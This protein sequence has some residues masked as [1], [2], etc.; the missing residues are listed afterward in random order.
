MSVRFI[1]TADWQLG[2]PF[3]NVPDDSKRAALQAE[4]FSVIE[5]IASAAKTQDAGFVLIAGDLFDSPSPTKSVVSQACAAIG[6]IECPVLLIPGNHDHGGPGSVWTQPFF[7]AELSALAPNL[8]VLLEPAPV[9]LRNAVIFPCPLQRR[10]EATDTTAWLRACR[11]L[12]DGAKAKPRI[13]LAHGSIQEFGSSGDHDEEESSGAANRVDLSRLPGADYD[14]IALGD[15]HGT[16]Q[17]G[18]QAWYA[19]TPEPDRFPKGES[20]LPGNIL[21]VEAARGELPKVSIQ[22]TGRIGWHQLD[23]TVRDDAGVEQLATELHQRFET[24]THSDLL[25]LDL[26]GSLGLEAMSA[27]ERLRETQEARLLRLKWNADV[28][29][30]PTETESLALTTRSQDPLIARVANRLVEKMRSTDPADAAV[31]RTALRALHL[32]LQ[33]PA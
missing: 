9:E 6:K 23:F 7:K 5:R 16:K 18:P 21:I 17:V 30:S 15:W 3:A 32:T 33:R 4:R 10:H 14:Y 29:I 22:P 26:Q 27:L 11:A 2:K 19:G 31:A 24:R 20:N 12:S 13:V 25:R 8:Q 28:L 1:H